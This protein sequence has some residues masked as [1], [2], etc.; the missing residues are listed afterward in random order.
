MRYISNHDEYLHHNTTSQ[1]DAEFDAILHQDCLHQ[2]KARKAQFFEQGLPGCQSFLLQNGVIFTRLGKANCC[3]QCLTH[4][5]HLIS[6]SR[7]YNLPL[8][9]CA[10]MASQLNSFTHSLT[11][12]LDPDS[13]LFSLIA[14]EVPASY[15]AI[16]GWISVTPEV[17]QHL[18]PYLFLFNY[19]GTLQMFSRTEMMIKVGSIN[20]KLCPMR[21]YN[22]WPRFKQNLTDDEGLQRIL[23]Q[24]LPM[25]NP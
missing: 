24:Q 20:L 10:L 7:C 16:K 19:P 18:L 25:K 12:I 23:P 2:N 15:R 8:L 5:V 13:R 17:H 6:A 11:Y 3:Y 21:F 14:S 4:L 1:A 22:R 9:P